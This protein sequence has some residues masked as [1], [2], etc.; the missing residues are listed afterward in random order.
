M[1]S[2][3]TLRAWTPLNAID[4]GPPTKAKAAGPR[5]SGDR[6]DG[7]PRPVDGYP[8]TSFKMMQTATKVNASGSVNG[9]GFAVGAASFQSIEYRYQAVLFSD[10][11]DV[12]PGPNGQDRYKRYGFG[13]GVTLQV[14]DIEADMKVSFGAFS[15][16]SEMDFANISYRIEAYGIN[17][18]QILE[19]LPSKTGDFSFEIYKKIIDCVTNIKKYIASHPSI[20]EL[21]PIDVLN[22]VPPKTGEGDTRSFYFG[23]RE[24]SVGNSLKEALERAEDN[25]LREEDPRIIKYMYQYFGVPNAFVEPTPSQQARASM[26]IKGEFNLLDDDND[27]PTDDSAW[28][29]V[30]G[31]RDPKTG[32]LLTLGHLGEDYKPH[33]LPDDWHERGWS[34]YDDNDSVSVSS[35]T[36]VAV[37]A[38]ADVSAEFD[39]KTIV[40]DIAI[41]WDIYDDTAGSEVY[42]TRYGIGVRMKLRITNIEFGVDIGYGAVGA[43][44]EL[45]YANVDVEISGLGIND[46]AILDDLP[47]PQDVGQTTLEELETSMKAIVDRIKSGGTDL[48]SFTPQPFM[49]EVKNETKVDPTIPHQAVSYAYVQ[50]KGRVPVQDALN[51]ASSELDKDTIREVY[52]D[53]GVVG[54]HK[55]SRDH[56]DLAEKWITIQV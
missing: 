52:K 13:L 19:Y 17:D 26:W 35:S 40:R 6:E 29:A 3:F 22:P 21:F 4:S 45:G 11:F 25:P 49:I 34:L 43:A 47:A 55:P 33:A 2:N 51:Q 12:L 48:S 44:S 31:V 18:A 42:Q 5:S 24:V 9:A 32:L 30:D 28:I 56:S 39:T 15:A 41:R 23:A 38:I 37:A 50:I 1:S 7:S 8:I 54:N 20:V 53:V 36:Q 10:R 16:A 27:D 46:Q 14:K